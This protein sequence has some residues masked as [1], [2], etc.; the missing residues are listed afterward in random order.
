MKNIRA[1]IAW[2]LVWWVGI[3]LQ[4]VHASGDYQYVDCGAYQACNGF[5][6]AACEQSGPYRFACSGDHLGTLDCTTDGT[7]P[8]WISCTAPV[9]T[10]HCIKNGWSGLQ[11]W[12]PALL[13]EKGGDGDFSFSEW[14][15]GSRSWP[16]EITF[17]VPSGNPG[18]V[19]IDPP[20][21][22]PASEFAVSSNT[23]V[24]T[25]A[26]GASCAMGIQYAPS[27]TGATIGTVVINSTAVNGPFLINVQ[28][29]GATVA[30]RILSVDGDSTDF[31]T[32]VTGQTES[33]TLD[34]SN[35]G[36]SPLNLTSFKVDGDFSITSNACGA[37]LAPYEGCDVSLTFMPSRVG[38]HAGKLTIDSDN[39]GGPVEIPLSGIGISNPPRDYEHVRCNLGDGYRCEGFN[40]A[41]CSD[42][43][44]GTGAISCQGS[45]LGRL[46][47]SVDYVDYRMTCAPVEGSPMCFS[48]GGDGG[49]IGVGSVSS[50]KAK[51][52]SQ[53]K[54]GKIVAKK[55]G[56]EVLGS[57]EITCWEPAPILEVTP[58]TIDFGNRLVGTP[59]W[60]GEV[61]FGLGA[62][63]PDYV[64]VMTWLESSNGG[65]DVVSNTCTN[66]L[67][68]GESCSIRIQFAPAFG[69]DE[70]G[71][72]MV[73]TNAANGPLSVSLSGNGET[74]PRKWLS[75]NPGDVN[76]DQVVIGQ[77]ASPVL[78]SVQN[79][80]NVPVTLANIRIDGG[81][82]IDSNTCGASLLPN[83]TCTVEVTFTPDHTG[84]WEGHITIE[85][86]SDQGV[87]DIPLHGQG[88]WVLYTDVYAQ[89][90]RLVFGRQTVG[91]TS[92]EQTVLI[93]NV[94][95]YPFTLAYTPPN[96][97]TVTHANCVDILPGR[98]CEMG[99][100]F[101]PSSGGLHAKEMLVQGNVYE[102]GRVR[103]I[104]QG[105]P[106]VCR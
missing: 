31:G 8:D 12:E 59:S 84:P 55:S 30:T 21:I 83:K 13:L 53:K 70:S 6:G 4:P 65:L 101:A 76:F 68:P 54:T 26:P 64:G 79:T 69:G 43:D 28:G 16:M 50:R 106:A 32:V 62:G 91:T 81:F 78:I 74:S 49:L 89:P 105:D 15:I 48:E 42:P 41:Q 3:A 56:G 66:G 99:I 72:L 36:N 40:G 33:I 24:G 37:T 1:G 97:Y 57:G 86:D 2:A 92:P 75:A 52:G 38:A 73:E 100:T 63:S 51:S 47:C 34:V 7:Y 77:P 102:P 35:E 5:G 9:G 39:D 93:T 82:V 17:A 95:D 80:G 88:V 44:P 61:V 27:A 46:I 67:A 25:L 87:V 29:V 19:T 10:P 90:S 104:G 58:T 103:L 23:C 85:S 60:D 22:T 98:T 96:G 11:C 45:G 14:L 18:P 71:R 20:A 94:G